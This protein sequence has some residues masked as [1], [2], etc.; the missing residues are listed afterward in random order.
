M[1][2][3]VLIAG[4][5][6]AALAWAKKA[7]APAPAGTPAPLATIELSI[8]KHG[9]IVLDGK[10]MADTTALY[11]Q[12]RVYAQRTPQPVLN[13]KNTEPGQGYETVGKIIYTAMRAGL[14]QDKVKFDTALPA[15]P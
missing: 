2:G 14:G 5:L 11:E 7:P 4:I 6:V 13:I 15:K 3:L 8:G 10:P 12:L 1:R 9:A